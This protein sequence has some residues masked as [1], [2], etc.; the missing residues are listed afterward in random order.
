MQSDQNFTRKN[1]TA[2]VLGFLNR[3]G[4]SFKDTKNPNKSIH[5][6]FMFFTR[7]YL[8]LENCSNFFKKVEAASE[9]RSINK[10]VPKFLK[11]RESKGIML[12]T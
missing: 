8:H 10:Y 6:N 5:E 12:T 11:Y 3:V 7:I 9:W 1:A 4:Y 2:N